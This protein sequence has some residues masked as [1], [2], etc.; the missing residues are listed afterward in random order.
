MSCLLNDHRVE[1]FGFFKFIFEKFTRIDDRAFHLL[2]GSPFA[3]CLLHLVSPET[4]FGRRLELGL[5]GSA[6]ERISAVIA[7]VHSAVD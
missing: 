6:P 7:S 5:G 1:A 3:Q 2:V 4:Q